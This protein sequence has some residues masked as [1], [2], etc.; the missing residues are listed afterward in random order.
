VLRTLFNCV[1]IHFV[2]F[3]CAV[4]CALRETTEL[5]PNYYRITTVL[6]LNYNRITTEL[7]LNHY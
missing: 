2:S 1:V 7:Q 6:L 5:L 4:I 3:G